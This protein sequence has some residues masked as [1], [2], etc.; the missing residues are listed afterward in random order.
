VAG[1]T[2]AR[3]ASALVATVSATP[4]ARRADQ[5]VTATP[6]HDCGCVVRIAGTSVERVGRT[7]RELL[8]FVPALLG[9]DPWMRKW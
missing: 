2:V 8:G 7:I 9:D 5:L 1:T 6:L 3:A 4:V